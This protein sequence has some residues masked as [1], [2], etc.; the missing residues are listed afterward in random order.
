MKSATTI[1]GD[2]PSASMLAGALPFA[3]LDP[4]GVYE[5]LR[6]KR[7]ARMRIVVVEDEALIAFEL[8]VM[9]ERLGGEVPATAATEADA[10]EAVASQRP[11]VVL[12]DLGLAEGD[13]ISAA[14]RIRAEFGIPIVFVT[15]NGALET[16]RQLREFPRAPVVVKPFRTRELLTSVLRATAFGAAAPT[17][18]SAG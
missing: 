14:R 11:D 7:G 6:R 13:G 15:A 16:R 17:A 12:M 10:L 1:P 5:P 4:D 9:I 3:R 8:M 18:A 2:V